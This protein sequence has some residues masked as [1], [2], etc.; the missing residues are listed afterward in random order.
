M[1]ED[2]ITEKQI[3]AINEDTKQV[4]KEAFLL[5]S[6]FPHIV[7]DNFLKPDIVEK[8]YDE[9]PSHNQDFWYEYN[10]PIEKKLACNNFDKMP[11]SIK[12]ILKLL[13]TQ[14]YLT[15]FSELTGIEDLIADEGLHGGGMHCTK[16]GGKLDMHIDYSIHP[17]L[18]LERRLNLIIYLNKDWKEEYGGELQLW[19][20]DMSS[21]AKKIFPIFNRAV[22]FATDDSSYHGH[23]DPITCPD[24]IAR[25]SLALYYLTKPRDNSTKRYKALF[26]ARPGDEYNE[27]LD[28]LR[29]LRSEVSSASDVYRTKI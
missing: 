3:C 28:K 13:N 18:D 19:E 26:V 24:N 4:K 8:I 1:S 17:L 9:F 20:R 23:P 7:V 22:I 11:N 16:Q 21:C 27:E 29:K 12:S 15:L 25:K 10:N 6:P 5:A 2:R 14:E